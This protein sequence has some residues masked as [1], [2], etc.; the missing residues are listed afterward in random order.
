M[1]NKTIYVSDDDLV[2]YERAQ[3]LAGGNLS[4][5]VSRALRQFVDA[6]EARQGGYQQVTVRVGSG[7]DRREQRFSG[8]LLGEW[9]H[10]TADRSIERFRVYRTPKGKFALHTSRMPDWAAWSDPET[11]RGGW[12]WDWNRWDREGAGNPAENWRDFTQGLKETLRREVSRGWW[13]GPTD[14]DLDVADSLEDLRDKMPAEFYDTL[15]GEGG[16]PDVEDLDI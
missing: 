4:A 14:E 16:R 2:L 8:V 15:V 7:R 6:E 5:A 9:R 3:A 13:W 10:P 12:H 1:P 11:W